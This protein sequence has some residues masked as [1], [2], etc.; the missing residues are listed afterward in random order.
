V[1]ENGVVVGRVSFLDA[2]GPSGRSWMWASGHDGQIKRAAHGYAVTGEEAMAA[3]PR[4]GT[5]QPNL[6]RA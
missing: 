6:G 5:G 1:F 2:V 3:S 4:A